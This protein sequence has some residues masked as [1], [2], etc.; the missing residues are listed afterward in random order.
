MTGRPAL[1]GVV[2]RRIKETLASVRRW[3]LSTFRS[4]D[5]DDLQTCLR[6][7]GVSPGDVVL[8]HGSFDAFGGFRGTPTD[9]I[10]VLQQ[11]VGEHG[12]L[13]M[14]TMPF[15]G[16]ALDFA[17]SGT[18]L[19]VRRTASK[20]GLLSEVFRRSA[21][22]IRSVHPTHPVAI[23]G[24]NAASL[25][26]GHADAR[27]PCGQG[28]PFHK[29]LDARGKVLFLGTDIHSF[30]FLHTLEEMYESKLPRSP[31]T[32]EVFRLLTRDA[33]GSLVPTETRLFDAIVAKVRRPD[34]L[35]PLLR[36]A[37]AWREGRVG[38]LL[39]ACLDADAARTAYEEL[40]D[41]GIYCY[42]FP[43]SS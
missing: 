16:L 11:V 15:T 39:V 13:L 38:S 37:H 20:M 2:K 36:Q 12:A 4:F 7:I 32:S 9:V 30:T 3:Y 18:I 10:R 33:D 29:L 14:P 6:K 42:D 21:K 25:A 1:V 43:T 34:R 17:R 27:T 28:S 22:V 35:V 26:S 41:R 31:F 40:C 8:V 19:D 23:W 5:A 24:E